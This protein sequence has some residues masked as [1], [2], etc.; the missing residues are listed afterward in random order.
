MTQKQTSN[1]GRRAALIKLAGAGAVGVGG[2]LGLLQA[3]LAA[4]PTQGIRQ[5]KGDVT[6]DGRPA[7]LGQVIMPGQ[8]VRTGAKSQAVYVVGNDAFLQREDSALQFEDNALVITLRYLNGKILSVFGKQNKQLITP[9]ATIGIRGTA[10]YIE[11]ASQE[12]YLCLCYGE[13]I[14]RANHQKTKPI[15]F[16]TDHHERPLFIGNQKGQAAIRKAPMRNHT[17]AELILLEELVGRLPPFYG[18]KYEAY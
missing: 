18:T 8:T 3:A 12:T 16:R 1:Q 10:C 9:T 13:V 2:Y 5:L 11:A 17:D 15:T 7:T 14:V 6:I 4:D